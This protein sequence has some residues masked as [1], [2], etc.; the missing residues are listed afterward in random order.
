MINVLIFIGQFL[1]FSVNKELNSFYRLYRALILLQ[2]QEYFPY[3]SDEA[4]HVISLPPLV[5]AER[6]KVKN[7]S[8][9]ILSLR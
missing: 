8:G 5:N 2:D 7:L 1:R 6:S 3:L 4:G 9:K